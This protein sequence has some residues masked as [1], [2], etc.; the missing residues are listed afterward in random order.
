MET[1]F[2]PWMSLTGGILIGLSA[3]LLMAFNGRIAGMTGILTG[4]IPP[5]STDWAWRIAFLA[6]AVIGPMVFLAAGGARSR[7]STR[8][9]IFRST[10]PSI[11]RPPA[12]NTISLCRARTRTIR[13]ANAVATSQV[14]SVMDI[15]YAAGRI[16][17][18]TP[19]AS[20]S[21]SRKTA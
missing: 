6:G 21:T 1:E 3:I 14:D 19:T 7:S 8:N 12:T 18:D 9:S 17:Y 10:G 13:T 11:L 5:I 2:T 20:S 4:I 16:T 15:D